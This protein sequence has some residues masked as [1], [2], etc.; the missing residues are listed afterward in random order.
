[1]RDPAWIGDRRGDRPE[2]QNSVGIKS[3]KPAKAIS[4][5][6]SLHLTHLRLSNQS[7][8]PSNNMSDPKPSN[9]EHT[10]IMV[11]VCDQLFSPTWSAIRLC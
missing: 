8:P 3:L 4:P 1:M 10:Y 9:T 6:R 5:S 2:G 11:K 7:L